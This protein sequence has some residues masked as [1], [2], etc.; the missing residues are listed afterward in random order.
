MRESKPFLCF[1]GAHCGHA[2]LTVT[3]GA[4]HCPFNGNCFKRL[5]DVKK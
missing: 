2:I 5:E 3:A 1:L 4:Y